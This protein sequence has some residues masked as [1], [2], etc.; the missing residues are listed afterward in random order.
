MEEVEDILL[1]VQKFDPAGIAARSL[2]EC[3]M[4]QLERMDD[5]QDVDVIVAK[6]ILTE[7]YEEFTKKHYPK[8]PQEARPR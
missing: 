2:Q 1:L 6:R 7:C 8:I 5:G 3:L 4:L